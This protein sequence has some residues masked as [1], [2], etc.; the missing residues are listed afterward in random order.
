ML[1]VPT[2]WRRCSPKGGPRCHD[3]AARG[4]PLRIR[5][6]GRG[7]SAVA[8][9]EFD[10]MPAQMAQGTRDV[11]TELL[12]VR[13]RPEPC[14]GLRLC[15]RHHRRGAGTPRGACGLSGLCLRCWSAGAC[16]HHRRPRRR[17]W[18][19]SVEDCHAH[20][21]GRKALRHRCRRVR[22]QRRPGVR[23]L[24]RGLAATPAA[25]L[26]DTGKRGRRR[27]RSKKRRRG[28]RRRTRTRGR[29][30]RRSGWSA[31]RGARRRCRRCPRVA[32]RRRSGGRLSV[33]QR[34]H[35]ERRPWRPRR[36]A[37]L[38]VAAAGVEA[39]DR[40]DASGAKRHC[41]LPVKHHPR[42]R[43]RRFH[44]EGGVCVAAI[45]AHGLVGARVEA[46]TSAAIRDVEDPV[47]GCQ[48]RHGDRALERGI[49][50]M[51]RSP[52]S[53]P[54]LAALGRPRWLVSKR[55]TVGC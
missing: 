45:H 28:R 11:G 8:A 35:V 24:G 26:P 23:L 30:R 53:C 41:G 29:S 22:H 52:R 27:R 47:Y 46:E 33:R 13:R 10:T 50:P 42:R 40:D 43:R 55:A 34:P 15:P 39:G 44:S 21:A 20:A 18:R 9:S 37:R 19:S 14:E 51:G 6:G 7:G 32:A 17:Q 48:E 54:P 31:A 1:R 4:F 2:R 3:T 12:R 36:S 16:G 5:A 38:C 49:P 25:A